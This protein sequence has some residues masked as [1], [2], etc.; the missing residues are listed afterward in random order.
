ML[1]PHSSRSRAGFF[2]KLLVF[3]TSLCVFALGLNYGSE[4]WT[5]WTATAELVESEGDL[6]ANCQNS[7]FFHMLRQHTDICT[8]VESNRR[9]G[10]FVLALRRVTARADLERLVLC[11]FG[12]IEGAS[13]KLVVFAAVV[14]LAV[15]LLLLLLFAFVFVRQRDPVHW[16]PQLPRVQHVHDS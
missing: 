10:S 3:L 6:F 1:A 11:V 4:F 13:W 9:L 14:V 15:A 7:T 16:Y 2:W 5:E 8:K 12:W